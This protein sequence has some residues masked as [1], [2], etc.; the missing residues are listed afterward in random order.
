MSKIIP[1]LVTGTAGCV[2]THLL[3]T[4]WEAR[5]TWVCCRRGRL[6]WRPGLLGVGD[7]SG[8]IEMW[9][10]MK[11]SGE[12]ENRVRRGRGRRLEPELCCHIYKAAERGLWEET[13]REVEKKQE[14]AMPQKS[15]L[16]LLERATIR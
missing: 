3:R 16:M 6:D 14:S 8:Y 2:D 13:T 7:T 1:V 5:K 9:A 11:P 10:Q 12:R 4:A 15:T